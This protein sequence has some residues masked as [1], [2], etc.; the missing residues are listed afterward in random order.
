MT[1]CEN[2][3][4]VIPEDAV[5]RQDME[6]GLCSIRDKETGEKRGYARKGVYRDLYRKKK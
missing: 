1:V 4:H 3:G 2:C 6:N 5:H